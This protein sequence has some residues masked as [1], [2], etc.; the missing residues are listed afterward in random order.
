MKQEKIPSFFPVGMSAY[1]P[2][3]DAVTL[4]MTSLKFG[5]DLSYSQ[6]HRRPLTAERRFGHT[7]N[8]QLCAAEYSDGMMIRGEIPKESVLVFLIPDQKVEWCDCGT[9]YTA[10]DLYLVTERDEIDFVQNGGCRHYTVVMRK[11]IFENF[12]ETHFGIP[13]SSA[14]GE[15][16]ALRIEREMIKPLQSQIEGWLD[17]FFGQNI[18]TF[19]EEKFRLL[20]TEIFDTFFRHVTWK[21]ELETKESSERLLK[22]ARDMLHENI[23]THFTIADLAKELQVS[24][25]SLQY[26]FRKRLGVTPKQYF[27][28][29]RMNAIRQVLSSGQEGVKIGDVALA[30]G[31]LH[32][33]HFVDQYKRYFGELPSQT[34]KK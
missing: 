25:R 10:Y 13:F 19:D 34:V 32:L 24:E 6:L 27:Q 9:F 2:N 18:Q 11:E 12:F 22:R 8:I 17:I 3:L 15:R 20:E 16:R 7:A 28:S 26:L 29:V 23:Q 4:S 1:L 21:K 31:F 33:G 30:H 14:F 5:W